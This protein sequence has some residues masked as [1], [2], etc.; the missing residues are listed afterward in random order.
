MRYRYNQDFRSLD[1][2]VPGTIALLLLFVPAILT[3]LAVVRE[4]ELGSITNFYVTPVTRLEFLLGKQLPY[5][6]IAMVSFGILVAL[7]VF[8]FGVPLK[9]SLPAL[10]AGALLY[11]VTATGFGLLVS[12]FT[13]TQIA[14]LFGTAIATITPANQFSG[15]TDPVS[16]LEGVGRLIG[17]AFPMTY[18]LTISRGTFNKALGFR[19]LGGEFLALAV[20]IPLGLVAQPAPAPEASAVSRAGAG[21]IVQLGIKE[22]R[23]VWHDKV[24]LLFMVWAFSFGIYSAATAVS[25]ELHH[26]P[27]AVVDEDRSALSQRITSAFYRP[28]F[29]PPVPIGLGEV[30]RGLDTGRYTFVL[31]IPPNFQRDVQAGRRPTVQLN[32]DATRMSQAFIGATYIQNIVAGEVGGFVQRRSADAAPS[33]PL[34]VRVKFNPNL[35]GIWF[36]GVMKIIDNITLLSVILAGAAL[37]REREHGTLEHLLVM[38]LTPFQIMAAKVWA[39]GAG[40]AGHRDAVALDRRQG[41]AGRAHRRV[42]VR[43]FCSGRCCT[44]SRRRRSASSW[45]PWPARCRSSA[46]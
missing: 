33:V 6:A 41:R 17:Q 26:A 30:D 31:D 16:S 36:G 11:V 43:C 42:R 35:N 2:M 13:R 5:V 7:A 19:D 29:L 40:G 27:I 45:P 32:I 10:T 9:G 15:L 23:S 37:I 46:C 38:P 18:F 44:C 4:K 3:A 39:N 8:A 12:A 22:L 24:L 21:A 20:F 14:A 1:A 34:V 28:Y 25:R